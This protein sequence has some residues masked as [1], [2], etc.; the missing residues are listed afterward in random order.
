[1]SI[2]TRRVKLRLGKKKYLMTVV[3]FSDYTEVCLWL[4]LVED[5]A[6]T[7]LEE[8]VA[9]S[10]V[11]IPCSSVGVDSS[12]SIFRSRGLGCLFECFFN[13]SD[14]SSL[15]YLTHSASI[16]IAMT[17]SEATPITTARTVA[18]VM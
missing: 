18:T 2:T 7:S 10:D 11:P 3:R 4:L 15:L 13:S 1:M 12:D 17:T 5:T 6:L 14:L 16:M 9:H 8:V